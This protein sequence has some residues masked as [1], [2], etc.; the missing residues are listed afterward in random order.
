[1]LSRYA[2]S[3][4]RIRSFSCR[5]ICNCN[6]WRRGIHAASGVRA[7]ASTRTRSTSRAVPYNTFCMPSFSVWPML[8][9]ASC[10][11]LKAV[12]HASMA[13]RRLALSA[14]SSAV[15]VAVLAIRSSAARTWANSLAR[16][17][18]TAGSRVS[19]KMFVSTRA[20]FSCIP[21]CADSLN[22]AVATRSSTARRSCTAQ[23][24][25]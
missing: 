23:L 17:S 8:V 6:T 5:R 1:M 10:E 3:D 20:T 2:A 18:A 22:A 25:Q 19:K 21:A 12:S 11:A 14:R 15:A 24:F 13:A 9:I 4:R 7:A 16:R